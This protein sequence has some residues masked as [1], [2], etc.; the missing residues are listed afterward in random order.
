MKPVV[1]AVMTKLVFTAIMPRGTLTGVSRS[2]QWLSDMYLGLKVL[3]LGLQG[4]LQKGINIWS[5]GVR[6]EE[7]AKQ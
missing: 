7:E 2:L 6:V 4:P 3:S 5:G 1:T